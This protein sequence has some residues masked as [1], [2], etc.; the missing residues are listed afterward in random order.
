MQGTHTTTLV[1][2]DGELATLDALLAEAAEGSGHL[3]LIEGP[4]GIGKSQLLAE[5]RERGGESMTVVSA[6]ASELERE[7]PFGVVRQLFEGLLADSERRERL[8]AGA[9]APAEAVF[10]ALPDPSGNGDAGAASFAALHGLFWLA[11]NL[12]EE[13]PL[14]LAVDDLQWCD[15]PSLRFVAYLV[16]RLEGVPILVPVTLRTTDPG[17]DQALLGE[18]AHDP[19]TVALRPGPLS[20]RGVRDLVRSRLGQDADEGFC[21]ACRDSTGGN[22]LLLRQ[23]MRAL[24]ADGVRPM[25]ANTGMVRD[26]GPRAVSRTVLLRLARQ[27]AET[28]AVARAV[29]VLGESAELAPV[30]ALAGV[31]EQ[32]TAE[33]TGELARVE[34]LRAEPPLGFVHPLVRDAVYLELPPS[35]RALRHA[36]AA[37][38]LRETGAPPDQVAAQLLHAPRRGEPWVAALLREAGR[39]A[40]LRGAAESAVAYLRRALEEPPAVEDRPGLLLELGLTETLISAP[41]AIDH[42]GAAYEALDDPERRAEAA[43][44]L[45]RLW[46]FT[47]TPERGAE[48]AR[49]AAAALPPGAEA[50]RMKFEALQNMAVF[51]GAG[52]LESVR[53]LERHR[54]GVEGDYDGARMLEAMAAYAWML[55][56]GPAE[57]C[58]RLALRS[59]DGGVLIE[60]DDTFFVVA[61]QAVLV[62]ADR[63]EAMLHWDAV[64]AAAHRKGSLFSALG[65]HLWYGWTLL[66]RGDLEEA[67]R[68]IRQAM[69]ENQVWGI[70]AGPGATYPFGIL[71]RVLIERGNPEEADRL[72]RA[73]P[74]VQGTTDG[75]N[76]VRHARVEL[77]LARGDAQAA[78]EAAEDYAH[79]GAYVLNPAHHPWRHCK[80]LALDRA[81]RTDDA[82]A[83]GE[84][85]LDFARR[86][87][88]P[89]ALG[90]ALRTLGEARRE[91]GLE[92]LEEAVAVLAPSS[93][94][95]E[96]AK[97]LAALGR[98]LRRGRRPSDAREP[99]RQAL[100]LATACGA[101]PLAERARSELYASGARPRSEALSGVEALTPSERRV[102]ELAAGGDSNKDIA[103]SLYVTPK[104]VEVHLS[105]AYRK[106]GI[107]SRRE[108][109]GA[110]APA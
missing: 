83:L 87:G 50:A 74:P 59:L 66:A 8:L 31:D 6:R 41:A 34:I 36:Q 103:Q 70:V 2:R 101:G 5:A 18:I 84:E 1:E 58:A 15:R 97:A 17:T 100:E 99:L 82:I 12:A 45:A 11:L 105:S 77:A 54:S 35:A 88:A 57:D 9:A 106:L 71:A 47:E 79:H 81:G 95:L 92:Q 32:R 56:A 26:I 104:T 63:E 64:R 22:P 62:A 51:F 52:A 13:R 42:L 37:A 40:K 98:A 96:H 73:S 48:I 75:E 67:E 29:A 90:R 43:H 55:Q 53:A 27:P 14:L 89:R 3:A 25:A 10:G 93:A 60:R 110:L 86:F 94:K 109:P 65:L 38:L 16:R 80:V 28:V 24:E 68:Q 4:A 19:M 44:E 20:E 108:L 61:A 69:E 30:A 72:L 76:H 49:E 78:L 23:L 39:A 102:A 107:R 91:E 33:A 46:L 21:R 85:D 7:F